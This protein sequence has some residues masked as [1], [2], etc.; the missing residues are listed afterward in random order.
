MIENDKTLSTIHQKLLTIAREND[1]Q[2]MLI[3]KKV[4]DQYDVL[5]YKKKIMRLFKTLRQEKYI[6]PEYSIKMSTNYEHNSNRSSN[7]NGSQ[8][9]NCVDK[10]IDSMKREEEVCESLL[11]LSKKL[12]M[13]EMIYFINTFLL[14]KTEENIADTI[15][16]SK[17]SLQKIKKS[18]LVKAWFE[19]KIYLGE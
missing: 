8:M 12:T 3:L 18:C 13:E 9:E 1:E 6:R 4:Y 11:K 14:D 2:N 15:G 10:Y 19:L 5:E 17:T 7:S 16:I